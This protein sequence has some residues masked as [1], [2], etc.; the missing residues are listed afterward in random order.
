MN[1]FHFTLK[2]YLIRKK[3][4]IEFCRVPDD[5]KRQITID[6]SQLIRFGVGSREY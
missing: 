3:E 5:L 6:I 1:D 2:L 4:I